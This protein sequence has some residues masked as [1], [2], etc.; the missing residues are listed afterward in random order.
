MLYEAAKNTIEQLDLDSVLD[1]RKQKLVPLIE[2]IKSKSQNKQA[3]K[4]NFICTHNSRRSQMAQIWAKV[5]AFCNGIEASTYSGGMELTAFHPNAVKAMKELGFDIQTD[6]GEKSNPMYTLHFSPSEKGMELF[7]KVYDDAFNP[8]AHF[9]AIMTCSQADEA[10]PFVSGMDKRI[11]LPYE[12]PKEFDGEENCI[13]KYKERS[14]QIATEM[15]YVMHT[16]K[17]ELNEIEE[18]KK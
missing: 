1:E 9:A 3:V 14:L 16:V 6:S 15:F 11:S 17:H 10:C 7:S 2:Y 5:A 8:K 18:A 4:L 13:A 12:D